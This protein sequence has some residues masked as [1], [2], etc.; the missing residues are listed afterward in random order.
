[1]IGDL[2]LAIKEWW[3]QLWCMHEYRSHIRS[4][5][6]YAQCIKCGKMKIDKIWEVR[7]ADKKCEGRPT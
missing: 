4:N 7:Y 3:K 2:I 6:R 5:F 1:M